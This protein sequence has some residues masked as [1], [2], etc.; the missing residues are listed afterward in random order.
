MKIMASSPITS[1]QIDRDITNKCLSSQSY[2]FS[3]S[4]VWMWELDHKE[5]WA[6]KNWCFWTVV[7]EKTLESLL[8]CKE[9]QLVHSKGNQSCI[10]IRR[11]DAEP[12]ASIL[13]PCDAKNWLIGKDPDP[14]KDWRQEEKGV[15]EDEVV[16]WHHWL[17]GHKFEQTLEIG[18]GQGNLASRSP[19]GGSQNVGYDW[20]TE[21]NWTDLP[22]WKTWEC[23]QQQKKS[24]SLWFYPWFPSGFQPY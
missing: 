23:R 24:N 14:A 4:R 16:G 17:N 18:D 19:W 21:L 5:I 10:L 22:Q 2:G 11:T 20:A 1:W 15:T 9:V 3:S 12:E 13:W 7:L 8:D 6:L